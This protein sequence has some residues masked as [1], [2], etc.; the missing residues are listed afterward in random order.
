[1]AFCY[2]YTLT[3]HSSSRVLSKAIVSIYENSITNN[4]N[5]G[6]LVKEANAVE[7]SKE[8]TFCFI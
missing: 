8:I 7:E 5:G 3:K 4:T 6:I 1:M 2:L